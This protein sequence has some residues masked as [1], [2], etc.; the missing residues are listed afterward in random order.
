MEILVGACFFV[1][2][3]EYSPTSGFATCWRNAH[4]EIPF[5]FGNLD[6]LP[7]PNG[8]CSM[9]AGER[10]I[11]ASMVSAW[12]AMATNENPST[13]SLQRPAYDASQSRGINT[14]VTLTA[15]VVDYSR[16]ELWDTLGTTTLSFPD[17]KSLGWLI[18]EIINP[19]GK[20]S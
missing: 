17:P 12:T 4:A 1:H 19:H 9:T 11:S 5:V 14:N 20:N 16:C 2:L 8:N 13:G 10:A 6:N 3:V 18:L 7:L 15:G